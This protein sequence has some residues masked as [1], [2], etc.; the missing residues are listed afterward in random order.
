[1]HKNKIKILFCQSWI[2]CIFCVFLHIFSFF[3]P[4]SSHWQP[5]SYRQ[6][7][8]KIDFS[9][10]SNI[11]FGLSLNFRSLLLLQNRSFWKSKPRSL[12]ASTSRINFSGQIFDNHQIAGRVGKSNFSHSI[13]VVYRWSPL[14]PMVSIWVKKQSRNFQKIKIIKQRCMPQ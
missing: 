10:L 6:L 13:I 5:P 12:T 2:F 14:Y 11:F 4:H 8:L 1:M 3:G 9:S 7:P